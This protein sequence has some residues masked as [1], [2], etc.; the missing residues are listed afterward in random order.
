MHSRK[1]TIE[2]DLWDE[3]Y[4]KSDDALGNV[5]LSVSSRGDIWL[6]VAN[7]SAGQ[8]RL[9][10]EQFEVWAPSDLTRFQRMSNA[11]ANM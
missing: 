11:N 6:P 3:D 8:L 2:I 7:A 5:A 1:Q 10:L 9:R 4:G